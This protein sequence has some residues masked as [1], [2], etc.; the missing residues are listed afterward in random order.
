MYK[1]GCKIWSPGCNIIKVSLVLPLPGYLKMSLRTY[2][3][4]KPP[5][6]ALVYFWWLGF[7]IVGYEVFF[8]FPFISF[9]M[10]KS[11]HQ[12]FLIVKCGSILIYKDARLCSWSRR[13]VYKVWIGEPHFK[14]SMGWKGEHF[15]LFDY[16]LFNHSSLTVNC[17]I[18]LF[19]VFRRSQK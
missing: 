14:G 17:C 1:S 10:L 2:D 6:Q 8:L 12:S 5:S 4:M 7:S 9:K 3:E 16:S 15:V 18:V 19:L 11:K 13:Q